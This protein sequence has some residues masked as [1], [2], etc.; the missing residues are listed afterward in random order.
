MKWTQL[1]KSTRQV[2]PTSIREAGSGGGVFDLDLSYEAGTK[3]MIFRGKVRGSNI[4][5]Y[6]WEV[7]FLNVEREDNLSQ[8]ELMQNMFPKPSLKN[9]DIQ[10]RCSC[11]SFRF[12]F[13]DPDRAVGAKTGANFP[14]QIR[15]TDRASRNPDQRPGSCK[16]L[17]EVVTYL[18]NNGFVA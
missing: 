4:P 9:N 5:F 10:L 14:R 2:S 6:T 12:T 3:R 18:A 15:K 7:A 13:A 16:H 11:P 17:I 8:N 1:V